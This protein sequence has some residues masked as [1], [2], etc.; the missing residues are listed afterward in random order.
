LNARDLVGN[1]ANGESLFLYIDNEAPIVSLDPA[2]V[3]VATFTGTSASCS[4]SFDPLGEAANDGQTSGRFAQL[5]AFVWDQTNGTDSQN[6]LYL[7]GV[8]PNEVYLYLQA[9]LSRP[10]LVDS[11]DD[12]VCDQVDDDAGKLPFQHL[13]AVVAGGKLWYGPDDS[14]ALPPPFPGCAFKN[15]ARPDGLCLEDVSDLTYVIRQFHPG[16]SKAP[17]AVYAPGV[18]AA[19]TYT[20]TGSQWDLP[21]VAQR[22]GW[23]CL[24]ASATDGVKNV[25]ISAPLRV[26]VDDE[27]DSTEPDCSEASMPDCTDGCAP[28]ARPSEFLLDYH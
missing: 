22:Q 13:D 15:E 19:E 6:V 27:T 8:D 3:R 1:V 24:A 2:N 20:C 16:Q 17:Q 9:D 25:G 14:P 18:G 4:V 28:P 23:M 5:R 26:C 10:L 21:S 7:A 11:D 12:G